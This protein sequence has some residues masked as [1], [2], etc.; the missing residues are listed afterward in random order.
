MNQ[1]DVEQALSEIIQDI[2]D[3]SGLECPPLGSGVVPVNDVPEFDSKV[4]IAATTILA[5]KIDAEIP[6]DE[7]IFIDKD[8]KQPLSLAEIAAAVCKVA[9]PNTSAEEAA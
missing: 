7:N 1:K 4:W 9:K 3:A 2:Q 5:T 8:T 6:D